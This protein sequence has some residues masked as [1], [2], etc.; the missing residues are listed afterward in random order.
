LASVAKRVITIEPEPGLFKRAQTRF[1]GNQRI[2]VLHGLSE[3]II[4]EILRD[5][6]GTTCCFWL[7][8][9]YS[10][11]ITHQGPQDTPIREELSAIGDAL[12]QLGDIAVFIDDLRCFEP[13]DPQFKHYPDR[14]FLVDWA[15]LHRLSWH[16]EHDIF[17]AK[18]VR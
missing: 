17:V 6:S 10:A 9:H 5:L 8:G 4:P 12:Q 18:R 1:K 16:I 3:N 13:S 11:G 7:D 15:R 2:S 14:N